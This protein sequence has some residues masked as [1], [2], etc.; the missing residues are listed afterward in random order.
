[1]LR[2]NNVVQSFSRSGIPHDNAVAEVFFSALKNE[3]L[4]RMNFKSEQEFHK[5]VDNH[6]LF[7][8]TECPHGTL[9]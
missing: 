6:I 8:N 1:M 2:M 3:E 7:Y 9:I 4:Y 5:S